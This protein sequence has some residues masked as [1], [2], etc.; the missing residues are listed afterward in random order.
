MARR[1][2]SRS[3]IARPAPRSTTRPTAPPPPPPQRS[4]A[5]PDQR[6]RPAQTLSA[7]AVASGYINSAV[8]SAAYTITV[9]ARGAPG[10]HHR[11]RH[12][13]RR[14]QTVTHRR[15]PDAGRHD[16]LHHQRHQALPPPPPSMA[17]RIFVSA[18]QTLQGHGGGEPGFSNSAVASAAYTITVPARR[19]RRRSP[20]ATPAPMQ[21]HADGDHRRTPRRAAH[22]LLHHQRHDADD[23]VF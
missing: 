22:D 20:P 3:A 9:P 14:T 18:T 10:V 6:E 8:A 1:R 21:K 13:C 11:R 23:F 2:A 15:T 16:L 19:R 12:L 4:I 17:V 5:R 7:M